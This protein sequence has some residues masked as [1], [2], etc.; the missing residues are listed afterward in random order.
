[1]EKE[2]EKTKP[3]KE[4]GKKKK[5]DKE[6]YWILGV[7]AGLIVVFL[8][9][10]SIIQSF[11][12]VEYEGLTFGKEKVGQIDFFVYSYMTDKSVATGRVVQDLQLKPV[13]LYFRTDP[14]KND[15]PVQGEKIVFPAGKKV[16]TGISDGLEKC[17]QS[18]LAVAGVSSFIVQNGFKLEAG[19]MN[20]TEAKANDLPYVKCKFYENNP[21]IIFKEGEETSVNLE[22]NCYEITANNCEILPAAEKFILQAILDAKGEN[23]ELAIS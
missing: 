22:G 9:A 13:F 6:L 8:A 5:Q 4:E 18:T 19:L 3:S 20:G 16:F 15:V 14:R 10:S 21:V 1:M 2:K 11:N 23:T 12:A 17:E 7:M